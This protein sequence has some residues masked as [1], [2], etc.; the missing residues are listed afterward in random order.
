MKKRSRN[1][2]LK[3]VVLPILLT[4]AIVGIAWYAF[5]DAG[6]SADRQQYAAALRRIDQVVTTC[7]AIEGR[8]APSFAYLS[9]HYGVRIDEDQYIVVYDLFASNIRPIVRLLP[10]GSGGVTDEF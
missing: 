5:A 2:L 10:I 8:Y 1:K 7:Y 9:E 4:A 6:E 3:S